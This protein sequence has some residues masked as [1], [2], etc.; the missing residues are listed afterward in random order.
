MHIINVKP[1]L[2]EE[3]IK[4]LEGEYLNESHIKHLV[5]KDTIVYNENGEPILVLVKNCVPS[6]IAKDAYYSLRKA[7]TLTTNRGIASGGLPKDLKVGDKW[8]GFTV[9]KISNGRVYRLKKDG[10]ISNSPEA[11]PVESGIIGYADRYPRIPYCRTTAF[12]QKNFDEYKKSVPYI[13][14]ISKLF[15]KY[16]PERYNNQ[17]AKYNETNED[18][19]IKNTVFTTVTVNRNFRTAAHYDAGDLPEGFGN[20]GVLSTG[21][22]KGGYTVIPRYG[23]AVDVQNCDLAL[24]DVHELHGNTELISSEPFERI[25]V[26]AYFRKKMVNCGS[27]KEELELAKNKL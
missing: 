8:R 2:T 19:K 4:N 11:K 10:T 16:L 26:V 27:A 18:F 15:Q 14:L 6:N 23:V 22:Y 20:L 9:G 17:L 1:I 21:K 7:A 3:E 24:F 13:Q 12:T 5:N 25:S